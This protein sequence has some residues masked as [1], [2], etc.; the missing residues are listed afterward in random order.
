MQIIGVIFK[1]S[2]EG[3]KTFLAPNPKPS[4]PLPLV[5]AMTLHDSFIRFTRSQFF[6]Y[7]LSIEL[8][9]NLGPHAPLATAPNH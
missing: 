4:K 7:N 6:L 5:P 1:S 9:L 8:E 2:L 3:S